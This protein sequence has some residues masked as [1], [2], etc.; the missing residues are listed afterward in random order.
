MSCGCSKDRL[1]AIK[2]SLNRLDSILSARRKKRD[3]SKAQKY[4]PSDKN[5]K[6]YPGEKPDKN[7]RFWRTMVDGARIPFSKGE[8]VDRRLK[9]WFDA[10][11]KKRLTS[12]YYKKRREEWGKPGEELPPELLDA[13]GAT[14]HPTKEKIAEIRKYI[15]KYNEVDLHSEEELDKLYPDHNVNYLLSYL[16]QKHPLWKKLN[17][18]YERAM[19]AMHD[20]TFGKM[21]TNPYPDEPILPYLTQKELFG[22]W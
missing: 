8:P 20:H 7:G 9:K 17:D 2:I 22:K 21:D 18:V 10:Y 3:P 6:P 5:F 19:D 1:A 15:K 11:E 14:M 12:I 16:S 4:R 13:K